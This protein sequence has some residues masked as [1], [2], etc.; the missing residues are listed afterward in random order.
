MI[1]S[2]QYIKHNSRLFDLF[3]LILAV[4][5]VG[6]HTLSIDFIVRPILRI[7]VPIFF[8]ISSYL[9][10]LK[11][12]SC[13]TS[14]ERKRA[15]LKYVKR[16][17]KLYLFW[18]VFWFP[19]TFIYNKWHLI[20]VVDTLSILVRNFFFG[21]TF[22][23]SWFLMAS[24]IGVVLVWFFN[25]IRVKD[26]WIVI[27]GIILYLMC[28]LSSTYSSLTSR[29]PWLMQ[30]LSSYEF[31]FTKPHNSFPAGI[32]FI[33]LGKILAQRSF[34]V[35]YKI[36]IV[37][38]FILFVLLY[39]EHFIVKS[40]GI[41]TMDDCYIM[42]PLLSLCLFIMVGQNYKYSINYDTKHIRAYSTIIYCSHISIAFCLYGILKHFVTYESIAYQLISFPITLCL[43]FLLGYLFLKLE[44][45][46]PFHF[47]KYSH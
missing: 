21:D 47:L 38:S 6:V 10:F 13:N 26:T 31:I 20:S 22:L 8:I 4:L 36:L 16:I 24:I 30:T 2:N 29:V 23:G 43:S 39:C 42:L 45:R 41:I 32:L 11:Q 40:L 44:K 46:K 12:R 17:L 9:F 18:F 25:E 14:L 27:L 34:Y 3:K 7:G 5:I 35:P 28:C 33:A 37:I 15:L 19:I 1:P